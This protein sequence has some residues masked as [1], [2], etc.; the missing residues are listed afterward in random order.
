MKLLNKFTEIAKILIFPFVL[1]YLIFSFYEWSFNPGEWDTMS[2]VAV[3]FLIA[4]VTI[5]ESQK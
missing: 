5:G 3:V 1:F 2:R 4:F